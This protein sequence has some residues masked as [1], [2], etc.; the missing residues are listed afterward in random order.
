MNL[1]NRRNGDYFYY[2]GTTK[3]FRG[4]GFYVRI[5][6]T[7]HLIKIKIIAKICIYTPITAARK[8][9]WKHK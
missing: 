7:S 6:I 2:Y 5:H 4:I 9:L 1:I 8:V 3:Y